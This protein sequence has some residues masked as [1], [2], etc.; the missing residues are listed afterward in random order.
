MEDI[1]EKISDNEYI[2]IMNN[3]MKIH[4]DDDDSNTIETRRVPRTGR[5]MTE[6]E[7]EKIK[8]ITT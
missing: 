5:R 6:E 3:L 4:N 2:I 7:I 1:K 8:K